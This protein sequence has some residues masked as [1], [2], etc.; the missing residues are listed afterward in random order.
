MAKK[1]TE[2]KSTEQPTE[3]PLSFFACPNQNCHDFNRFNAG[4]LSIAER[5]GKD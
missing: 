4:N 5:M 2:Q 3:L 1:H